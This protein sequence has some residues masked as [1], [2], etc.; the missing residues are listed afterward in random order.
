MIVNIPSIHPDYV[1]SREPVRLGRKRAPH[2]NR[3]IE[4]EVRRCR[5]RIDADRRKRA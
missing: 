2:N 4:A 3:A 1:L 5:A